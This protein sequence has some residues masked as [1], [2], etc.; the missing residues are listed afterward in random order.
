MV[1]FA[2]VPFLGSPILSFDAQP[3]YDSHDRF[4]FSYKTNTATRMLALC[5]SGRPSPSLSLLA[6]S[7]VGTLA[8]SM[9]TAEDFKGG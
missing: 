7:M 6:A 5:E 2:Q 4:T 1:P 8:G 9:R 3:Y